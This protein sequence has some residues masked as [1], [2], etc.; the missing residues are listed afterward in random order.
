MKRVFLVFAVLGLLAGCGSKNEGVQSNSSD[1]SQA[2]AAVSGSANP[3][4]AKGVNYLHQGN[5]KEAIK[6]FDEAIRANPKD[7]QGYLILGQTYMHLK[8]Y[9]R[10]IDTF[11]VATRVAPESG[12]AHYL[13]AAN[14]GLAGNFKMA[15]LEAE[16]SLRIFRTS[17]DEENFKR[18]LALLQ[19]LP[20]PAAK[21]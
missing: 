17:R 19:S 6:S 13:L 2:M 1:P 7:V 4:I 15:Q 11:A 8:D 12:Q 18:S 5:I 20:Q 21:P 10:A 14:F 9:S 3:N 16:K